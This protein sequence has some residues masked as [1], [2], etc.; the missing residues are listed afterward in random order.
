[1]IQQINQEQTTT[2]TAAKTKRFSVGAVVRGAHLRIPAAGVGV[3]MLAAALCLYRLGAKGLWHDEAFSE[4]VAR[5]DAATMWRVIVAGE[6]Y[7]GLYYALLHVWALYGSGEAWLRLPS[8]AFAVSAAYSLFALNRRL[9]GHR[10]AVISVALLAVNALF[11]RYAQEARP[12]ALTLFLVVWSTSLFCRALDRPSSRNWAIYVAVSALSVYAHLF[13]AFVIAAHVLLLLSQRIALARAIAAYTLVT[14]LLLPLLVVAESRKGLDRPTPNLDSL[15]GLI[16]TFAGGTSASVT[17]RRV[18]VILYFVA[19][20]VAIVST[21]RTLVDNEPS[22]RP[23]RLRIFGL[24]ALWFVIPVLGTFAIAR[25]YTPAALQPKYVIVALPA[26]VT[27]AAIGLSNLPS[28]VLPGTCAAMMTIAAFPLLTY[29]Q[30]DFKEGE[31]WKR[32]VEYVL[33]DQQPADGIIFLSRFGRV[34]FEYYYTAKWRGT[35]SLIPIYP[36][37]PWGQYVPLLAERELEPTSE[38]MRRVDACSRVWVILLWGGFDSIHE[39]ATPFR[40]VLNSEYKE[41]AR[42]SF[43][44]ELRIF[45]YQRL[46]LTQ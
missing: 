27:L 23:D 2:E 42:S 31:D 3:A 30:S 13:A 35:G 18:L 40:L 25:W 10:I 38:A 22:T 8:V 34:P 29:Y 16:A 19:C 39:D 1:V 26:F 4:A 28:V 45:L 17:I 33:K 6:A 9:L 24:L 15:K 43:G 37:T 11:V 5:L 41:V 36:A 12:Y 7:H 21:M 20:C 14:V 46:S 44:S 32:A